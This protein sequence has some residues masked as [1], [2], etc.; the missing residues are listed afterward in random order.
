MR[1]AELEAVLDAEQAA[2][3]ARGMKAMMPVGRP[4]LDYALSALADAGVR[5]VCL[6]V[7][8]DHRE[9]RS[10]YEV[11]LRP[12]RLQVGFA[13][14][15]KPRGTADALLAAEEFA[16]GSRVLMVNADNWYPPSALREVCA[17]PA[18]G[19]PGFDAE[20]LVAASNFGRERLQ[21][22]G[23]VTRRE[24]GSLENLI[25]KPDAETLGATPGA[26]I[27]MNCWLFR[28]VIFEAC[29][30]VT[31]S[32]RGE[33][34]LAHAVRIAMTELDERFEVLPMR[35]GVLD[36]SSRIDVASVAARLAHVEVSL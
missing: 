24:D 6:V 34:E 25:E 18:S 23:L 11:D 26:L 32:A 30:R 17:L 13:V 31:P 5:E 27:T 22:F 15:P 29:R 8:P 19:L 14:Q 10:R 35:A 2:V 7:G 16:G 3:A 36:L 21:A 12:T 9:I 20:S 1:R 4:F 28:P 33:L